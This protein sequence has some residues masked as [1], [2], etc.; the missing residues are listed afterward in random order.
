MKTIKI[1]HFYVSKLLLNRLFDKCQ[2]KS[3]F[4]AKICYLIL[5]K[6]GKV[7][8]S[9]SIN[10]KLKYIKYSSFLWILNYLHQKQWENARFVAIRIDLELY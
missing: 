1:E 2:A 10:L 4:F 9:L 3:P 6:Q 7:V 8:I 5:Q